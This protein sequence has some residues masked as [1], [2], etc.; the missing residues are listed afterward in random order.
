MQDDIKKRTMWHQ[1]KLTGERVAAEERMADMFQCESAL[2]VS[3]AMEKQPRGAAAPRLHHGFP[4]HSHGG[5]TPK[6]FAAN[7]R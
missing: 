7:P 4:E 6:C 2:E 5:S 3:R 1:G